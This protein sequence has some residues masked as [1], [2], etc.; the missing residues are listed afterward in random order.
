M[1]VRYATTYKLWTKILYVM[2]ANKLRRKQNVDLYQWLQNLRN[3]GDYDYPPD[4]QAHRQ[5]CG[6]G[7]HIPVHRQHTRRAG[8]RVQVCRQAEGGLV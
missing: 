4:T 8:Y 5:R 7:R 2:T 6:G 1:F 3:A